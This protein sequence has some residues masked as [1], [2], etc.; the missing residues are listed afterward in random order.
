MKSDKNHNNLDTVR[1]DILY[2]TRKSHT[3]TKNRGITLI[4]L[5]VTVIILL[6]L[7]GISISMIVGDN[8]NYK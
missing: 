7:A 4:S 5:V 8:R 6:I 1:K 2:S 3:K